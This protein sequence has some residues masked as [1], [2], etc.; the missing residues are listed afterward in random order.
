MTSKKKAPLVPP[1]SGRRYRVLT[2]RLTYDSVTGGKRIRP[3]K[4]AIIDDLKPSSPAWLL[5][6]GAIEEVK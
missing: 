6:A 2:D 4:G 5:E 3:G 1:V